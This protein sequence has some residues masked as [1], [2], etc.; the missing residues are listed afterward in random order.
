[1]KMSNQGVAVLFSKNAGG[2]C[3]YPGQPRALTFSE[4]KG[5]VHVEAILLVHGGYCQYR[6]IGSGSEFAGERGG[7]STTCAT[8]GR[9]QEQRH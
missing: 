8:T 7:V 9:S 4:K 2:V 3:P 1:M 6:R 5:T